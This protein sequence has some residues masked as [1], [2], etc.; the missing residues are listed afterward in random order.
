MLLALL[1]L[2]FKERK[3]SRTFVLKAC[4]SQ[5]TNLHKTSFLRFFDQPNAG[6]LLS[7]G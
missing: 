1:L 3:L 6:D 5:N 4:F 2:F 7:T